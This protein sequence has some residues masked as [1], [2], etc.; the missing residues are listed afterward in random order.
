MKHAAKVLDA[1][2]YGLPKVKERI[3]EYIAV[4]QLAKE[5][6]AQPDPVLRRPARR[7]Q[8]LPRPLDRR[9]AGP[10]VRAR[11]P[12]RH[13]RRGGDS[14]PPAHVHRRAAGPHHP[15]MRRRAR[16]TRSSCSTRST[17][18]ATDFRGDPSSALLEV[19][20]PEQNHA[21]SDHYLDVDYDLSKVMFI[22]TANML[23]PIIPAL[24]DRMEVIELRAT[25]RKRSCSIAQQFLVPKQLEEHGLTR[26]QLTFTHERAAEDRPRVHPRGGRAQPGARDRQHLPQGG[27]RSSPSARRR[28]V[29]VGAAER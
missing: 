26:L 22:T 24:R 13:P 20:D 11:Q 4:R 27:A 17:R 18:S 19:L 6:H 8:D 9:G 10:Q 28:R 7:R 29:S 12:R 23:D 25:S 21:F 3:L 16:S 15:A 1:H 14:R 2:H 5:K